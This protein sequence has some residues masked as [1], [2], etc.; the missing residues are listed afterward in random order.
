MNE[1]KEILALNRHRYDELVQITN[2]AL[3]VRQTSFFNSEEFIMIS[4]VN[5][6]SM[7]FNNFDQLVRLVQH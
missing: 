5:K 2:K 7:L 3:T 6:L 1:R 4:F